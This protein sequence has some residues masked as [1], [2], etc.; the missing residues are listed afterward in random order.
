[1]IVITISETL[2]ASIWATNIAPAIHLN[3]GLLFVAGLAIVRSHNCWVRSWPVAVT[4]VGWFLIFIGLLRMFFPA[5]FLKGVQNTGNA[6]IIPTMG[7]LL[8]GIYLT[9][10]AYSRRDANKT[11]TG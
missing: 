2:N 11:T 5:Y 3:G 4:L 7:V 9:F 6:F 8:I 10:K 1:M